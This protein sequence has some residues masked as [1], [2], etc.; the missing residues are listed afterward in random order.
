MQEQEITLKRGTFIQGEPRFSGFR[1]FLGSRL[2]TRIIGDDLNLVVTRPEHYIDEDPDAPY[3]LMAQ[4]APDLKNID[5]K[6]LNIRRDIMIEALR[7]GRSLRGYHF[8]IQGDPI[9][10][11]EDVPKAEP[12]SKL[13]GSR[14]RRLF[15]L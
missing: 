4:L 12:L 8:R 13:G 5:G 14:L 11:P 2:G 3:V 15:R 6:A 9:I 1:R 10:E 7:T